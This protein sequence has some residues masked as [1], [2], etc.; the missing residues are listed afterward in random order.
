MVRIQVHNKAKFLGYFD[1]L[2]EAIQ[3]RTLAEKEMFGELRRC[4]DVK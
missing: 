3:V 1:D 2:E 4:E